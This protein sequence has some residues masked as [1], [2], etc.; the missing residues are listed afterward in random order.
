MEPCLADAAHWAAPG[1]VVVGYRYAEARTSAAA[2]SA[3]CWS[4]G[5]T[6]HL[7]SGLAVTHRGAHRR[8][9]ALPLLRACQSQSKEGY[10]TLVTLLARL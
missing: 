9:H 4:G 6:A 10:R 8:L 2:L 7:L 3:A 5:I 1:S